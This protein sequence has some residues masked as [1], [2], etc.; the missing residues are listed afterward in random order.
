MLAAA[1]AACIAAAAAWGLRHYAGP[2]AP[3]PDPKVLSSFEELVLM[4]LDGLR[5]NPLAGGFLSELKERPKM[6]RYLTGVEDPRVLNG[7]RSLVRKYEGDA[8]FREAVAK[9]E[10]PAQAPRG[11]KA[12]APATPSP[13]P[14]PSA[15]PPPPQAP[16]VE[17]APCGPPEPG[18]SPAPA[19]LDAAGPKCGAET[20]PSPLALPATP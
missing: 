19:S 3:E 4:R 14:V 17:P 8:G 16:A 13:A 7:F 1:A 6:R 2:G 9:A 20:T 12:P 10:F 15:A 11:P 5:G 18:K